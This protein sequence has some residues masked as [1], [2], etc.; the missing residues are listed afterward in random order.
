MPSA[1][2]HSE[3]QSGKV[4]ARGGLRDNAR[5]YQREHAMKLSRRQSL[6]LVAGAATLP[7][8]SRVARAQTYPARP[9]RIIVGFAAGG[10]QDI[11]ARLIG[12][13][14]SE[15]LGQTLLID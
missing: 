15:R 14:L 3:V 8:A 2:E 9:I 11:V 4:G 7:V 1:G 5:L 10:G 12:Q 6:H 13:W